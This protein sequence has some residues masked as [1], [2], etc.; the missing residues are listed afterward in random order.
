MMERLL[1]VDVSGRGARRKRSRVPVKFIDW[2]GDRVLAEGERVDRT[3]VLALVIAR[4]RLA[5]H[6]VHWPKKID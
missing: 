4:W 2:S 5:V 3:R 1:H 6:T